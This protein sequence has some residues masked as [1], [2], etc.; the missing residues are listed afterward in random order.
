MELLG[1]M[2]AN[3]IVR[4]VYIVRSPLY[5]FQHNIGHHSDLVNGKSI[6]VIYAH[7]LG[8]CYDVP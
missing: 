4:P 5:Q 3:G 8:M 7:W 6:L 1:G 2:L